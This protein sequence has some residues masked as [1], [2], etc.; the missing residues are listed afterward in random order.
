MFTKN[1]IIVE[2][3]SIC[4][5]QQSW[6]FINWS[7]LMRMNC[8]MLVVEWTKMNMYRCAHN[9]YKLSLFLEDKYIF[10]YCV[11]YFYLYLMLDSAKRTVHPWDMDQ[12]HPR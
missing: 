4:F 5:I 1:M 6:G 8:L 2:A 3:I 9:L 10:I 12:F 11:H 7:L